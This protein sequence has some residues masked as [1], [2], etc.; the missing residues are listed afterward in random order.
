M[1][2]IC[3]TQCHRDHLKYF[4]IIRFFYNTEIVNKLNFGFVNGDINA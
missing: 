4:M 1:R 2:Y 3:Y